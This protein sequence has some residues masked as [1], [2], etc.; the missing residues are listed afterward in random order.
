MFA[1]NRNHTAIVKI[2]LEARA[3]VSIGAPVSIYESIIDK[4]IHN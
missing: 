4:R 2:L 3:D 1:V